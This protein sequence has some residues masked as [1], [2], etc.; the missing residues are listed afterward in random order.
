VKK[1]VKRKAD[2]TTP[3]STSY[4]VS[5]V[6]HKLRQRLLESRIETDGESGRQIKIVNKDLLDVSQPQVLFSK[7]KEKLK[8]SLRACNEILKELFSKKHSVKTI[9]GTVVGFGCQFLSRLVL[10]LM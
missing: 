4:D 1:G 6:P 2:T 8:E 10:M 5:Y 7:P 9:V 3:S